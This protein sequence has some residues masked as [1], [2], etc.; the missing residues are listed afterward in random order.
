MVF[1]IT[2]EIGIGKTTVCLKLVDIVRSS[3]YTCGGI[4]TEKAAGGDI[5]V[6]NINSGEKEI[7]ASTLDTFQEGSRTGKYYF[8][9][10]GIDFGIRSIA[11]GSF[12]EILFIDEIGQL[13]LNG[14]GFTGTLEICNASKA[15]C[16]L[17]IRK[18]LLPDYLPLLPAD[19]IIFETTMA[20]RDQLPHEI[21]G[22]LLKNLRRKEV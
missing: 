10:R 19:P 1:I 6:E 5:T 13:E 8:Y 2:G 4:L 20:N 14:E 18:W 15:Q 11:S 21:A 22:I 7:L 17:V 9:P 12:A 3:G 16:V